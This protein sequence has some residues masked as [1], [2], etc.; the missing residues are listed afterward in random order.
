MLYYITL[1]YATLY[2]AIL[3]D[4]ICY[5]V[6]LRARPAPG[7]RPAG[8]P[9]ACLTGRQNY[10]LTI[11]CNLSTLK[12]EHLTDGSWFLSRNEQNGFLVSRWGWACLPRCV[13]HRDF[14]G[15]PN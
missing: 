6:L 11:S 15:P 4:I 9:G 2:Y 12:P 1:Y 13:F 8:V 10:R 3:C 7:G 5:V 14:Q